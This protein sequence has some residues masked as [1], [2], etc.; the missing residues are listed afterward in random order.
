MTRFEGTRDTFAILARRFED[1][2]YRPDD[3]GRLLSFEGCLS[4]FTL[5]TSSGIRCWLLVRRTGRLG[6]VRIA[7]WS[8]SV[9]GQ[10]GWTKNV[11][12]R[13]LSHAASISV[14]PSK[15]V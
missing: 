3:I 15:L 12:F 10:R 2:S 4:I 11:R 7:H 5:H 13:S 14:A 6:I 8:L 9:F 1:S